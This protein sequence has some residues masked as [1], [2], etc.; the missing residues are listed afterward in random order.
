M[1]KMCFKI[2]FFTG[3]IFMLTALTSMAA[4][5]TWTGKISDNKCGA[6]HKAM[7][8]GGKK[9]SDH[10]CTVACVKGGAKYVFVSKGKVF[11][12]ENQDLAGL[13]D[14]AGHSVKLTGEL[15]ADKKTI[16][17]SKVSSH[18]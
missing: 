15:Q 6:S 10:D 13:E 11:D 14:H 4:E 5:K 7:E 17:A 12:I 8:H 3:L 16:K 9:V 2:C 18:M 1:R